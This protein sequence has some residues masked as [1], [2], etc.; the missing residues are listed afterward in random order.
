MEESVASELF[1][2]SLR[3]NCENR[4]DGGEFYII[5]HAEMF[6]QCGEICEKYYEKIL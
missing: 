4:K 5:F 6:Y 1:F 2:N 3:K